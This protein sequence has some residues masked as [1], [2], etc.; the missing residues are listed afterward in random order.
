LFSDGENQPPKGKKRKNRE[1]TEME[2]CSRRKRQKPVDDIKE[3][4]VDDLLPKT[5]RQQKNNSSQNFDVTNCHSN[6][7]SSEKLTSETGKY[8]I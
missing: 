1:Q 6:N 8:N 5:V 2:T 4:N 3:I 7:E